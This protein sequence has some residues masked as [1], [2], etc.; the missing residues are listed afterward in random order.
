MKKKC[1]GLIIDINNLRH[2]LHSNELLM[3]KISDN[4]KEFFVINIS[5]LRL[6]IFDNSFLSWDT[7]SY[8]EKKINEVLKNLPKNFTLVNPIN[9]KELKIF[10]ED[11]EFLLINSIGKTFPEF[12]IHFCLSSKNI[13]QIIVS[14][15]ANNETDFQSSS[16][17]SK[18]KIF[19]GK[20]LPSK[21]I[22]FL[23]LIR[24]LKKFE[25]RFESN[26]KM[27][28]FFSQRKIITQIYKKIIPINNR[29]FDNFKLSN[30]KITE[31]LIVLIDG[32]FNH[33]ED[34]ATRGYVDEKLLEEHYKKLNKLLF[35]IQKLYK[36]KVVVCIHPQYDL[37]ET[38]K[39]F[40]SF[41]TVKFHTK[42]N[43]YEAFMVLFFDSTS[44]MDA[45]LLKKNIISLKTKIDWLT[46]TER[47]SKEYGTTLIDLDSEFDFS[48]EELDKKLEKSKQFYDKFLKDYIIVDGDRIG[49]EKVINYCQE[50]VN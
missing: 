1:V 4:L 28:N 33:K 47:Y 34:I 2:Y 19:F 39:R 23:M 36:K 30:L 13:S 7:K 41:D 26:R 22:S 46:D 35:K 45:F 14:N 48:R 27:I 37:A 38:K 8:H 5:N 10:L 25:I 3:K 18:I 21:I 32:N 50:F 43:I 24:I 42:E 29:S 20:K 11:K 12:N 6:K 31:N 49:I 17:L 44:I 16:S 9:I 15:I 40:P